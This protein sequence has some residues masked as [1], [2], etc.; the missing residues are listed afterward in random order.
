[1]GGEPVIGDQV[2]GD[3]VIG[4]RATTKSLKHKA[5]FVL[6]LSRLRG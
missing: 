2:I 6:V 3:Q 4:L 1:V 5:F